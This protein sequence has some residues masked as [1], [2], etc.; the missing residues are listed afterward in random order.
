M[1]KKLVAYFSAGGVMKKAAESLAE[2]AAGS[3]PYSKGSLDRG[4]LR[5]KREGGI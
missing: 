4:D 3:F 1:S 2:A 5:R